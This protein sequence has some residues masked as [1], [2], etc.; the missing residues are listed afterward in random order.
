MSSVYTPN[1][2]NN[3]AAITLASDGD[4]KPIASVNVGLEG[5]ADKVSHANWPETDASKSYPLLSQTIVRVQSGPWYGD[6]GAAVSDIFS[7]GFTFTDHTG[8]NVNQI[9]NLPDGATLKGITIT[10]QGAGGHANLPAF[11]TD[12]AIVRVDMATG[13]PTLLTG[14]RTDPSA[15]V[16]AYQAVHQFTCPATLNMTE[17]IDN[18]LYRYFAEFES[19]RGSDSANGYKVKAI[20]AT[21]VVTKQDKGAS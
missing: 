4:L 3:P 5:L 12:V 6:V 15:N 7:G 16:P 19:E 1:P 20:S 8:L 11:P 2:A 17:V 14:T 21:L 13:T 9:L 18:T 10:A